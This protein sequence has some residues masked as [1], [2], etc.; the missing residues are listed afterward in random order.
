MS[1][2]EVQTPHD[3]LD[4]Y[5]FSDE[6]IRVVLS[7]FEGCV[8][9]W[10]KRDTALDLAYFLTRQLEGTNPPNERIVVHDG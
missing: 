10:L 4:V 8:S 9:I 6:D 2:F 3:E 1:K 5:V 7:G